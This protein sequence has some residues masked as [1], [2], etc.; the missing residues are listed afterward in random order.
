MGAIIISIILIGLFLIATESLNRMNK[1]AVAMFVGVSCWLLYI[2]FGSDFVISQHPVQFFSYI[3][4]HAINAMAVKDFIAHNIFTEYIFRGA[5]VVLYFLATMTIVEVLTNNGCFDFIGEWLRSKRPIT[6]LWVLAIITF[7]L[8]ANLDNTTTACLMLGIMHP[9]F[10]DE[11]MRKIYGAAII[12]AANCGGAATV[13]GDLTTLTLWTD[14]LITPTAYSMMVMP[15]LVVALGTTLTLMSLRLPAR[16]HL[17]THIPPYRGDDTILNRWQRMI[18][19]FVG[20]G[21]LWFIPTFHR[22]TQLPPFLGAMCVLSLLWIVNELCNRSLLGSDQMVRKRQPLALQ[23]VNIQNLLFFIGLTLMFGAA[24]ETG[25]LQ[26]GYSWLASAGD[27]MAYGTGIIGGLLSGVLGNVATLLGLT[28][29]FE[30][31]D[32]AAATNPDFF[33]PLLSYTTAVG[34]S[35]LAT[36]TITGLVLMRMENVS[37]KWY[38]THVMPKVFAGWLAGLAVLFIMMYILN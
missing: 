8:S 9:V 33:W 23:Y 27:Y 18:M 25:L 28:A 30:Q 22:I 14:G 3:S 6:L 2:A 19:F 38:A 37:L 16:I 13:I 1:A 36:G 32:L 7:L 15:S 11:R 12:L 5:Q 24:T 21:G 26:K 20:A 10:Q 35:L 17:G 4:S 31:P 29:L 34:G